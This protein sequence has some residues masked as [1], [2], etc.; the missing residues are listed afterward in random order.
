[1][2]D[3]Q[4]TEVLAE[5]LKEEKALLERELADIST[6]DTINPNDRHGHSGALETGTAD[7]TVL[8]DRFEETTTNEGITSALEERLK[9]VNDA[10]AR[11]AAG[12]Y[13]I[14]TASGEQIPTERLL[15][16]P[17]AE[18]CVEHADN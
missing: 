17:A 15:A 16:N 11:I 14:C 6:Q 2:V 13:G 4:T 1:M 12:T 8:A 10:L 7:I 9:N 5:R 3:T 18:T